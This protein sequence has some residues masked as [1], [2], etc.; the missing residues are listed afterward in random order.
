MT[1]AKPLQKKAKEKSLQVIPFD[2]DNK[3]TPLINL[4]NKKQFNAKDI[5][6]I[7]SQIITLFL[8]NKIDSQYAKDLV[9]LTSS[10]IGTLKT[11]ELE[12]RI[13]KLEQMEN[14]N[15]D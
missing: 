7:H 1:R 13:E 8:K 5:L 14:R 6:R 11:T 15:H 12:S 3:N 9:Y 4:P 2:S 10:Y